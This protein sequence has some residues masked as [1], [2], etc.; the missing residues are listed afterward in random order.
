MYIGQ[1]DQSFDQVIVI[2]CINHTVG[3]LLL[4]ALQCVPEEAVT[5]LKMLVNCML[6]ACPATVLKRMLQHHPA[7]GI[8]GRD[9]VVTGV[10]EAV[11][12]S[13]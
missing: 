13:I 3:L 4:Q 6:A 8:F 9:N 12:K 5:R 7:F 11:D 10:Y 1:L 2:A